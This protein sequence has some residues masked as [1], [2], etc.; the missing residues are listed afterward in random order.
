MHLLFFPVQ[1]RCSYFCLVVGV[2]K[3]MHELDGKHMCQSWH[4]TSFMCPSIT[5]G[6]FINDVLSMGGQE[7]LVH[8]RSRHTNIQQHLNKPM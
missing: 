4:V 6:A 3:K 5:D 1:S 2:M 8:I 7:L